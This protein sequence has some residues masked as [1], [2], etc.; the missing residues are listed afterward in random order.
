MATRLS[1]K[2]KKEKTEKLTDMTNQQLIDAIV[3]K[4]PQQDYWTMESPAHK[5]PP[6]HNVL[7]EN[8]T[9]QYRFQIKG[10]QNRRLYTL[11]Q[12]KEDGSWACSCERFKKKGECGHLGVFGFPGNG[13]PHFLK[14]L[15]FIAYIL[16]KQQNTLDL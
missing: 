15:R 8:D 4:I 5:L 7:K 2:K 14:D 11:G 3:S 16:T 9:H 13:K 10:K 6:I 1:G 12:S